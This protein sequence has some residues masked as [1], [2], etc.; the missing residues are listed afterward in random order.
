MTKKATILK[1]LLEHP[2]LQSL[3]C[4]LQAKKSLEKFGSI[5][6]AIQLLMSD[7]KAIETQSRELYDF[8]VDVEREKYS[9]G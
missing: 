4:V 2:N 5:H 9:K 8:I 6:L 1:G 7:L 3:T